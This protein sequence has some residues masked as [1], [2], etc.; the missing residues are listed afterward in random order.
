ME[1]QDQ[2]TFTSSR[3]LGILLTLLQ[4]AFI[5]AYS[6]IG[7]T[8]LP[9]QNIQLISILMMHL[10]PLVGF[11]FLLASYRHGTWL[12]PMTSLITISIGMQLNPLLQK[13]WFRVLIA[14][15]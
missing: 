10:L 4:I 3:P 14:G 6:I 7:S 11:G 5:T 2:N 9:Y 1:T 12:G 15:I 8:Y 13:L